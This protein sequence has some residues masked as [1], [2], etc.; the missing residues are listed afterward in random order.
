M[1]HFNDVFV[2]ARHR[3]SVGLTVALGSLFCLLTAPESQAIPITYDLQ[4][5]GG[6]WDCGPLQPLRQ[7][8]PTSLTGTLTVDSDASDFAGQFVDLSIQLL[9]FL[10]YTKADYHGVADLA[11]FTF[12]ASGAL[13][14]FELRNFFKPGGDRGPNGEPLIG[15]YMN[16]SGGAEDN[17][18]QFG[19]RLDPIVQ[20]SC[21]GCVSFQR[22]AAVPEPGTLAL[23]FAGLGGLWLSF[24]QDRT[25]KQSLPVMQRA[26]DG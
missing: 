26:V 23:F 17:R 7:G 20:N 3:R 10:T 8:C 24:K 14:G 1:S 12:D 5:S 4:I 13:S 6:T 11:N 18:F 25:R 9:D 21:A 16:L 22:A 19:D 15:F 2:R